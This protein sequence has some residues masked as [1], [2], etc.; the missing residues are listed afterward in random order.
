M[1][2]KLLLIVSA[3]LNAVLL[4]CLAR[5]RINEA[6]PPIALVKTETSPVVR[7]RLRDRVVTVTNEVIESLD[8]RSVESEDYRHFIANLRAI[9]CPEKTIAD[10]IRADVNELFQSRRKALADST[11]GF[12]FWKPGNPFAR[13]MNP[14]MLQKQQELTREQ[15]AILE[16]LL[17][18]EPGSDAIPE[19]NP[20][21]EL[22]AF[23]SP[24]QQQQVAEIRER[25][26]S[27]LQQSTD[28]SSTPEER[29]QRVRQAE[30]QMEQDLSRI[31]T[32]QEKDQKM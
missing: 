2:V 5:N 14:E 22:L 6:P 3:A 1:N 21:I 15:R 7:E 8:W 13:A 27:T 29:K 32:P 19:N 26:K 20:F 12:K 10:I 30:R 23:L 9:G 25:F 31:M 11:E 4:T 24:Q 16:E 18:K 28:G 17:G